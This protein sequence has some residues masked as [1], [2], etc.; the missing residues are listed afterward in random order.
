[1]MNAVAPVAQSDRA[2]ASGAGCTGSSPV[3]G[4]ISF[5]FGT[6]F[7]A[8]FAPVLGRRHLR[9]IMRV[10]DTFCRFR[11]GPREHPDRSFAVTSKLSR[12]SVLR[13]AAWFA[14]GLQANATNSK[15]KLNRHPD[16]LKNAASVF[17]TRGRLDP[18]LARSMARVSHLA[19]EAVDRGKP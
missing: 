14:V 3:G 4:A 9:T 13:A 6:N 18:L 15:T 5:V 12:R 10:Y 19:A 1:M 7:S 8:P 17:E 16:D 11:A 2:P